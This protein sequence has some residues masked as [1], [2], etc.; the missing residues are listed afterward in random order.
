MIIKRGCLFITIV[1]LL[2]FPWQTFGASLKKDDAKKK[3]PTKISKAASKK[4][5]QPQLKSA[6]KKSKKSLR[7]KKKR[8]HQVAQDR[9]TATKDAPP[10]IKITP[11]ENGKFLLEPMDSSSNSLDKG[12]ESLS[13]IKKPVF[14]EELKEEESKENN[15]NSL[16]NFPSL[17]IDI[18]KQLLGKS[19]RLGGNGK[20]EG[21]IDCSGFVKKIYQSLTLSLPHSSREQAKLGSLVTTEWDLSQLRI[22]DLLF[23]KRN[24]GA[25][26]GH[27]GMY[28]GDGKMIH[29][30]SKKG[31]VISNLKAS[32]Y[33]NRNFV[34]AKRLFILDD[35]QVDEFKKFKE[36]KEPQSQ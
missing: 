7:A 12:T 30:A 20:G 34:M 4:T 11:L 21:G 27:T 33:Y 8:S 9:P 17:L 32:N 3:N 13:L 19:Y 31:V 29:S 24:R 15:S 6:H 28:I 16:A 36:F 18:S 10:L 23:F 35:P 26:I 25:H 22:G 5:T 14:E 1:L 2:L